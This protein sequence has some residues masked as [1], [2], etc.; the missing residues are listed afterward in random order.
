LYFGPFHHK[1]HQRLGL[2]CCLLDIC[3][4]KPHELESPLGNPS[5]REAVPDNFPEPV[6]RNHTDWVAFK[7]VQK[8]VFHN[9]NGVK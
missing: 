5:H 7:V 6:Q 3:Y 1:V 8:L 4:V 2:D 9:Q